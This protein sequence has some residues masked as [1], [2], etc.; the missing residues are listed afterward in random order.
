MIL[1]FK[2]FIT[3]LKLMMLIYRG[4]PRDTLLLADT[5]VDEDAKKRNTASYPFCTIIEN[6]G[7][8]KE[9]FFRNKKQA[10]DIMNKNLL[11]MK[12]S[13]MFERRK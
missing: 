6:N 12:C 9:K 1:F 4:R 11:N 13:W 2:T 7:A 10:E 3:R 8:L 5:L